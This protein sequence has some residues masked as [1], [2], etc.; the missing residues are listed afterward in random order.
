MKVQVR[1][2]HDSKNSFDKWRILIDDEEKIV[3]EVLFECATKTS[4]DKIEVNG[5]TVE[6]FHVS[7][8]DAKDY[9]LEYGGE[10]FIR[11]IIL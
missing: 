8:I 2:N 10:T 7:A 4:C 9:I 6:K 3:S 1:Y 11:A 5:E